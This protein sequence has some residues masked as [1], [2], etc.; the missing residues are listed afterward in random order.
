MKYN[1]LWL[2]DQEEKDFTNFVDL[3]RSQGVQL[4]HKRTVE[5]AVSYV[6]ENHK[7]IDAAILDVKVFGESV[8]ENPNVRHLRTIQREL[9]T[10]GIQFVVFTSQEAYIHQE[11]IIQMFDFPPFEKG[12]NDKEVIDTIKD[13]CKDNER[14]KIRMKYSQ[15]FQIFDDNKIR[16]IVERVSDK[17]E[18]TKD[19]DD[20]RNELEKLLI[21]YEKRSYEKIFN[22]VRDIFEGLIFPV[23]YHKGI[24]DDSQIRKE[25]NRLNYNAQCG[26]LKRYRSD[27]KLLNVIKNII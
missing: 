11:E 5:E 12:V 7:T 15:P 16:G 25:K 22:G 18:M 27:D 21:D 17:Y 10:K 14:V 23:L 3:A 13:I 2:E 20:S 1:V 24:F 26:Q 8:E 6:K 9:D 4:V 19:I